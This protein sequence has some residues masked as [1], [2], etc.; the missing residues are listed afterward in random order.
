MRGR[1]IKRSGSHNYTIVLQLGLDPVTGRRKQRWIAVEGNKRAAEDQL[2]ELLHEQA[3]G[4]LV[5]P[6]KV[7]VGEWL[8]QWLKDY[9]WP[10]LAPRTAE[11]YDSMI[12]NHIIPGLGK[13]KLTDLK[14]EHLQVYYSER[15]KQGLSARTVRHHHVTLHTALKTALKRGIIVRNPADAVDPPHFTRPEIHTIGEAD[16]SRFL[17]AAQKTEY[18]PFFYLALF[19]GMR[20]S[21][22]LALRWSDVDLT[23][24]SAYV[25]RSL[26]HLRTGETVFRPTKTVK[27]RRSVALSPSTVQVLRDYKA[28]QENERLHAGQLLRKDDLIFPWSPDTVTHAWLKLS[29]KLGLN[30]IHLH[31]ARHSHASLLLRQGVHPKIVQERL[32]HSSIQVTLDTYSHVAPGLQEAAANGFDDFIRSRESEKSTTY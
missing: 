21:E 22:L 26:H 10:N 15:L 30:D 7:T 9:V 28:K 24:C 1:I 6:S 27:G 4:T 32:G 23:L 2:A 19:T 18:Y 5:K 31:S 16:L 14:P 13:H 11:G 20:R 17:D 29:R 3:Q 25:T 12:R 8:A